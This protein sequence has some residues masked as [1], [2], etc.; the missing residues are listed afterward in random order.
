MEL[1]TGSVLDP[2]ALRVACRGV[3]AVVHLAAQTGVVSS[4]ADP[5]AD[6][7]ANARGTLLALLA[8]RDAGVRAF[9]FAS[10]NATLGGAEPP[11]HEGM[12]PRP[13]S[14]Y[15]ASKLAGEAYLSAFHACYGLRTVALRFGN[16]YGPWS[17][18]KTSVIAQFFRDASEQGRLRIYGDGCQT[19]DFVHAEDI[20]RAIIAAVERGRGGEIYNIGTG[21]E[22]T[23][24]W[25]AERVAEMV[26]RPVEVEHFPARRGEMRR[27]CID[28][29]KARRELGY[30]PRI[31]IEDGLAATWEWFK[32]RSGVATQCCR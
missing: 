30:A 17:S 31:D 9:V 32:S 14:P 21:K 23:I 11:A 1:I 15:G 28:I 6:F 12:T 10:S 20:S 7:E 16:A 27:S 18:H 19:R 13:L 22:T 29:S 3:D 24:A 2:G 8:A 26:G 4:V 5:L 25:L